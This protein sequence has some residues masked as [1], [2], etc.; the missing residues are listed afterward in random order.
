M[1]KGK[2]IDIEKFLTSLKRGRIKRPANETPVERTSRLELEILTRI[3]R[4][5]DAGPLS[6]QE[7][8]DW[9][10]LYFEVER[11]RDEFFASLPAEASAL[12]SRG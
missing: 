10:T 7:L 8:C 12:K 6:R 9:A 5:G 2:R 11:Q 4:Y 3:E 1:K